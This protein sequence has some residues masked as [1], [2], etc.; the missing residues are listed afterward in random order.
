LRWSRPARRLILLLLL[1]LCRHSL[2]ADLHAE[3]RGK[4]YLVETNHYDVETDI[5]PELTLEIA[6]EMELIYDAYQRVFRNVPGELPTRLRVRI[7]RK[8]DDYRKFVGEQLEHSGGIYLHGF[9]IVTYAEGKLPR[10]LRETLYHEGFHQ[11]M[12]AKVKYSPVWLNEGLAVLFQHSIRSGKR[13][14]PEGLPP[15]KLL[16]IQK[17]IR[18]GETMSLEELFTM[19]PRQWEQNMVSGSKMGYLQYLQAW[20]VVHFLAFAKSKYQRALNAYIICVSRGVRGLTAIRKCFGSNLNAMEKAWK[21]YVLALEPT[22]IFVCMENM[23]VIAILTAVFKRYPDAVASIQSL[24]DSLMAKRFSGW[25][26][27]LA[28]GETM[29]PDNIEL[30]KKV[31]RCPMDKS[32]AA[33]SYEYADESISAGDHRDIICR[34]HGDIILRAYW[35]PDPAT[36]ARNI[37]VRQ[38]YRRNN[39]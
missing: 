27:P 13:L 5:S 24:Y 12:A 15:R 21:K 29:T 14:K 18:D 20:T 22:P 33:V 4:F 1:A 19:T 17:A 36:G 32:D 34:N 26:I 7:Y 16:L 3:K 25:K 2:A 35:Y 37:D 6:E 39:R 38:E 28:T 23:R 8:Q 11:F 10:Y 9:G 30:I 31:F